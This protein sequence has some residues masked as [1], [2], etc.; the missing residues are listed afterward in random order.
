M[1]RHEPAPRGVMRQDSDLLKRI[2]AQLGTCGQD[3]PTC[4]DVAAHMAMSPRTL[5]RRLND[6]GTSYRALLSQWRMSRAAEYLRD[7]TVTVGEIADRLGYME[8]A[9]FRHAFRRW[10]GCSPQAFR[11]SLARVQTQ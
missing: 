7:P 11:Y 2:K 4:Q 3:M 5:R 6:C 1:S 8:V 10:A 9:A